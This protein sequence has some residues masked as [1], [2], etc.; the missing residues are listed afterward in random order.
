MVNRLSKVSYRQKLFSGLL[1]IASSLSIVDAASAAGWTAG[2]ARIV[3]TQSS[4]GYFYALFG[5]AS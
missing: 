4:S 5:V 1:L 2:A 3:A